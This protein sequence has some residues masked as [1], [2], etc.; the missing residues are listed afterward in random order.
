MFFQV[1]LACA[2]ILFLSSRTQVVGPWNILGTNSSSFPRFQI[3]VR[4][5]VGDMEVKGNWVWVLGSVWYRLLI[6]CP[7]LSPLRA[8]KINLKLVPEGI[9]VRKDRLIR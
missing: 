9:S 7:A 3:R 8:V 4:C 5:G 1:L 2:A 6:L